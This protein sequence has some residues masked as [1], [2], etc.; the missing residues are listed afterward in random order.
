ME[1][2]VDMGGFW[3]KKIS[4]TEAAELE[5]QA[6]EAKAKEQERANEQDRRMKIASR[7]GYRWPA[8]DDLAI[9]FVCPDCGVSTTL[10]GVELHIAWHKAQEEKR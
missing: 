6:Q 3:G 1:E 2:I 4:A 5:Q 10:S 7:A 9:P 8:G